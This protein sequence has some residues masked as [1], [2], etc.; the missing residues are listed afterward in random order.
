MKFRKFLCFVLIFAIMMSL[1]VTAF[2][3]GIA[4]HGNSSIAAITNDEFEALFGTGNADAEY[5]YNVSRTMK[6]DIFHVSMSATMSVG[7]NDYLLTAAG[8]VDLLELTD[9]SSILNGPLYGEISIG[10]INLPL[11]AGF[12][13][14]VGESK[15]NAGIVIN[16]LIDSDA[17]IMFAFGE[18]VMADDV[19]V[20]RPNVSLES[21]PIS[22][23]DEEV[24]PLEV[25]AN[26]V[27]KGSITKKLANVS[28]VNGQTL[29]V[30]YASNAKRIGTQVKTYISAVKTYY[31]NANS[32][33][34]KVYVSKITISLSRNSNSEISSVLSLDSVTNAYAGK[35]STL[36]KNLII[37]FLSAFG[38][39]TNTFD[40]ALS[41]L[42]GSLTS[43]TTGTK[44]TVT[45]K[46]TS[47]SGTAVLDKSGMTAGFNI[48][49]PGSAHS[50]N[51]TV[52]STVQYDVSFNIPLSGATS[53]YVSANSASLSYSL[54]LPK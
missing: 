44:G 12:T 2:A 42:K 40:A 20:V 50:A 52:T 27:K 41:S 38:L 5:N 35:G 21:A 43:T 18:R 4:L 51:Y 9:G 34:S 26:F 6:D 7:E 32:T 31:D 24:S 11:T 1:G 17:Q 49:N 8:D 53:F 29:S 47:S 45:C 10:E 33:V 23:S 28:S 36:L 16:P 54:W 39:P 25:D 3:D 19:D 30:Y 37:D 15:I 46:Y 48:Y 14:S 13:K 22:P